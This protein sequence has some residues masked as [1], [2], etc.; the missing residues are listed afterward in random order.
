MRLF[1]E[2]DG[3]NDTDFAKKYKGWAKLPEIE[4]VPGTEEFILA[5]RNDCSIR[6]SDLITISKIYHKF[7]TE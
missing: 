1:P 2:D 5:V 4:V 3:M 7:N 6:R